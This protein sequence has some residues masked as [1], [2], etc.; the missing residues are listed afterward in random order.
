MRSDQNI[1]ATD[2]YKGAVMLMVWRHLRPLPQEMRQR[3]YAPGLIA[4]KARAEWLK[5]GKFCGMG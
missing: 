4:F 1:C 3:G 2:G 5:R